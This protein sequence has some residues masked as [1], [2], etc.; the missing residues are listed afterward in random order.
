MQEREAQKQS[1]SLGLPYVD[2]Q[3]FPLD[4]NV[5]GYF[6]E[7][8]AKDS[9][10]VPFFNDAHDLRLATTNPDNQLLKQKVSEMG[11]KFKISLYFISKASYNNALK[12]YS[13]VLRPKAISTDVVRVSATADFSKGLDKLKDPQ[14][15]QKTSASE[16]LVDL[17][18][19]AIFLGASDIHLEPEEHL[20]KVRFRIDGVLQDMVHFASNMQNK[21]ISRIKILS[22]L[23]LNVT[24]VPQDGRLSFFYGDKPIDVRVSLLPSGYGE[25]A[26]MRLL[27]VGA[28]TLKLDDLGLRGRAYEVIER[29]LSKPNG[30]TITTGPTGSGK[31]TTLYAFLNQLNAP[32]VKI[33][34]LEDPIEYKLEGIQQTPI[35]YRVDFSFVKGLRAILRQDPDIVMVGEI[36]DP[37]TAETALQAALTGHI[38]LST[39]HTNDSSG[40]IPRLVTMGVKPFIIAP[41]V[42][43]IIAQRLV[44]RL[45]QVCKQ[46]AVL[47]GPII[48]R[49]TRTLKNISPAAEVSVPEKLEFFHS[50]GCVACHNLGYQGRVGIYEVMEVNDP[51]KELI[52]KDASSRALRDQAFKDGMVTMV[53]DGLLKAAEGI[54]DVEEVFR[55]AG[56]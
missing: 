13:K 49:V 34:T 48:Q 15:Q 36:R 24:N 40:A 21:I 53:Q 23:K 50:P 18:G 56:D 7:A 42:N 37:E 39:L 20:L 35:D 25:A 28:T 30:M 9:E 2:L 54:T 27:G 38:V 51:M 10:S 43:A 3:S 17:F 46:P 29:Q 55:V 32:G 44:R 8:E 31:T 1:M 11:A 5:L 45:C 6:T 33:I 41:A 52:L 14:I 12:L 22:K 16:L 26:V 19:A 4:I 47:S